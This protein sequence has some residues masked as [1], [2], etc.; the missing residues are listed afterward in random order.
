MGLGPGADAFAARLEPRG[1]RIL[2]R[3]TLALPRSRRPGRLPPRQ[4]FAG[5]HG[6]SPGRRLAVAEPRAPVLSQRHPRL[7]TPHLRHHAGSPLP[8][9]QPE[10]P[11]PR[12]RPPPRRDLHAL[13]DAPGRP[14]ESSGRLQ[15]RRLARSSCSNRSLAAPN[16]TTGTSRSTTTETGGSSTVRTSPLR[17]PISPTER[18]TSQ[19]PSPFSHGPYSP[20]IGRGLRHVRSPLP[21]CHRSPRRPDA[22]GRG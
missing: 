12:F 21:V 16:P 17:P 9:L 20:E 4:R 13:V 10:R 18:T 7:G 1:L 14:L 11:H 8:R 5:F 22:V 15:P 19:Q 2:L 6:R 3:R